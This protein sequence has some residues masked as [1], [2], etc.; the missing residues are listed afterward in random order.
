MGQTAAERPPLGSEV[1]RLLEAVLDE[2]TWH[3]WDDPVADPP[4]LDAAYA[5]ELERARRATGRRESVLAGQGTIHGHPVAVLLSEFDFLAGSIGVAAGRL[6][7]RAVQRATTAG[8]PLL[9]SPASGGTRM[10]EGTTAFLQMAAVTT[11]L[12]EHRAAGLPFLVYLRHPTT[13]GV[14][15]SWGS[16]GHLAAAAPGALVGFLGPRVYEALHDRPFPPGVQRAENLRDHGVIDAVLRPEEL[17]EVAAR[18]VGVA[19]A[20]RRHAAAVAAVAGQAAAVVGAGAGSGVLVAPVAPDATGGLALPGDRAGSDAGDA[21]APSAADM[22]ERSRRP[23]RPGVRTL[24]RT[25]CTDVTVFH[26][27]GSG[28]LD[29]AMVVALARLDGVPCVLVGQ[30]RVRQRERAL[31][32]AGLRAARRGMRLAAE[33]HLPLVTVVDTPGAELS[34]EAEEA[35][36][37]GEIARCLYDLLALPVPT[38]CLLLG[39]GTGGAALALFPADRVVAARHAWLSPLPP[40]GA[41]AIIHRTTA[42]AAEMAERQHIGAGELLRRGVV[43]V[44][45]PEHPDAADEPVAFLRRASSVLRRELD[46]LLAMDERSRREARRERYL[47]PVRLV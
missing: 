4:G 42:R 19:T 14:L 36:L 30:D 26:A 25:V 8:L 12:Q 45:V 39:E 43:D 11:A 20:G 37:A 23:D 6:L 41:S 1:N 21:V 27:T 22:L 3:E 35:G 47:D 7:V 28:E 17:R 9:A 33:L 16:L 32:P 34:P 13:G 10:Q 5:A 24:L 38:V 31:H 46:G 15:A 44:V 2:G 29:E 40:E 18:V